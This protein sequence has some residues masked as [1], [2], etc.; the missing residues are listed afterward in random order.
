[1][2]SLDGRLGIWHRHHL[3]KLST[4]PGRHAQLIASTSS[5]ATQILNSTVVPRPI[6]FVSTLSAE[7]KPNLAPFRYGTRHVGFVYGSE[8][9]NCSNRCTCPAFFRWYVM[10]RKRLD[11]DSNNKNISITG[12]L[13]SPDCQRLL[14]TFSSHS[15]E[16]ARQHSCYE[17]IRSE[18]DQRAV[19]RSSQ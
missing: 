12:S 10:K 18:L 7:N 19:C 13:S 5:D 8:L 16:H 6:A 3:R 17:G 14:Q 15:Q 11:S 4:I 2:K 1:M 9:L